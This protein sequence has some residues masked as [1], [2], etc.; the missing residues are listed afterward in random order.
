MEVYF[1]DVTVTQTKSNLIQY[2]AR[3]PKLQRRREYYPFGQ[4]TAGS[5][6]R[7]NSLATMR[8]IVIL[9]LISCGLPANRKDLNGEVLSHDSV[10]KSKNN[11]SDSMG[12]VGIGSKVKLRR[13]SVSD[14][15][16]SKLVVTNDEFIGDALD[17]VL[18]LNKVITRSA[19]LTKEI[20][21][22][23]HQKEQYDTLISILR[24]GGDKFRFYKALDKDILLEADITSREFLFMNNVRVGISRIELLHAFSIFQRVDTLV[25]SDFERHSDF[26]FICHGDT[27]RLISFSARYLD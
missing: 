7:E 3:P 17:K 1:D 9:V 24:H 11:Y 23:E 22:N 4:Q 6:T 19:M 5:W 16:L 26:T 21:Q 14:F 15:L 2:N 12:I 8:Y 25:V 27:L 20:V 10:S 18:L 13:D